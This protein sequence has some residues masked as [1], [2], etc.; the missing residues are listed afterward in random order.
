MK[1]YVTTPIYYINDLPHIGSAYTTIIADILAIW[2][3]MKGDDTF[4]LT[5]LDENSVKTVQAAEAKG[6][7][8]IQKY[9]DE[10]AEK[11]KNAWQKLNLTYDDFIR[12]T[13]ERHKKN[14]I[15]FFNKIYENGDIYKGVYEGLY[16]DGCEEFKL[17]KDAPDGVCPIHKKQL[18]KIKEENYYFKLSKYRDRILEH[19][20]KNPDFIKPEKRRN[21]II[22]FLKQGL[23]DTSISRPGLKWGIDL[24][25]DKDHKFWVWFDA[26]INYLL[27]EKYWPPEVQ[28]LGKDIARF[29][30]ITW[31]GML[32]SAGYPLPKTMYVH[33]FF[34]VNGQ[35]MSKSLG[36][37]I[38]PIS[39]SEKY[40]ID[41]IRYYM[42]RD[43]SLGEDG[44]FSE[45]ALKERINNEVVANYSNL[46]YRITSFIQKNYNGKLPS[47]NYSEKE[48]EIL[49]QISSLV[50]RYESEMQEYEL[51]KA[52]S[53]AVEVST[54]ANKYIQENEPWKIIKENKEK[55]GSILNFGAQ[56]LRTSV[57]LYYPF[58]PNSGKIA[59][60]ALGIKPEWKDVEKPVLKEGHEL[61]AVMLFKKIET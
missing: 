58:M 52:L 35:K 3:R 56:L 36:N 20:E 31:I 9:T 34:T 11:W 37:A 32:M 49:K 22:S 61:K 23:I 53:T 47:A 14:V 30:C 18:K 19:I 26:L 40:T 39:L 55:A 54:I 16:C 17:E 15:K 29:H 2:H 28:L 38:D 10:M 44:D 51:T 43:I 25:I 57:L 42:L 6:Y 45:V 1:F 48:N 41:G 7:K 8:D 13:E 50:K 12:T 4:F 60:E 27:P 59:C 24:P 33:G 5:G 21:E 46:F